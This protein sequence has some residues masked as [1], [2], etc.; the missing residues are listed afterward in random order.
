M[1]P[2]VLVTKKM[3][4]MFSFLEFFHS[5]DSEIMSVKGRQAYYGGFLYYFEEFTQDGYYWDRSWIP[6]IST[7]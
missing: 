7:D 4:E 5:Y 2:S 6:D 3:S 1:S